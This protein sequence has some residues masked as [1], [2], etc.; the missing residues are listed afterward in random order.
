[1]RR[2]PTLCPRSRA[3]E[4]LLAGA[5]V[6]FAPAA[7]RALEVGEVDGDPLRLDVTNVTAISQR[8][9]A[10]TGEGERLSLIHI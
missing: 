5:F 7:A 3:R 1:M 2:N 4:V 9:L 6:F 10:R 8:F